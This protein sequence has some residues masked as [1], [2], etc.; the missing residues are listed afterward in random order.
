MTEGL[1]EEQRAALTE[2]ELRE[3]EESTEE[4]LRP[5]DT[6]VDAPESADD[7]PMEA[8]DAEIAID[9]PVT[10]TII[11]KDDFTPEDVEALRAE[12]EGGVS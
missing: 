9:D 12:R 10:Q 3:L 8:T 2:E 7:F 6:G 1:T 4:P 5:E 11:T